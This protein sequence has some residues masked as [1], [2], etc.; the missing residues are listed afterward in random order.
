MEQLQ[1]FRSHRE[2]F[3]L[4]IKRTAILVNTSAV[5]HYLNIQIRSLF[6]IP[7][8]PPEPDETADLFVSDPL[9]ENT[10]YP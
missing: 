4:V 2:A 7:N 10:A 3:T 9:L 8:C 1:Y 5:N 6:S